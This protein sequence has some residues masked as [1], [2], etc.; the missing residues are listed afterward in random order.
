MK[1]GGPGL[2]G[3]DEGDSFGCRSETKVGQR[4]LYAHTKME[5]RGRRASQLIFRADNDI[6]CPNT[7]FL[8]APWN[9]WGECL[10]TNEIGVEPL[11]SSVDWI[12]RLILVG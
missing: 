3:G 11:L 6:R 7:V 9:E 2:L 1:C 4:L 12:D 10:Q 5:I 8:N